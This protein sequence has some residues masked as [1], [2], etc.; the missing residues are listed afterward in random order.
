MIEFNKNLD[1]SR[2]FKLGEFLVS[3]KYLT[4]FD[5]CV[6]NDSEIQKFYLLT[7]LVLQPCRDRF[8]AMKI[9]SAYRSPRLNELVGGVPDSQHCLAEAVDFVSMDASAHS[10]YL[11]IINELKWPG[12]VI[13]Y[14]S[15][16]RLHVSLPRIG[17]HMNQFVKKGTQVLQT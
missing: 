10:V 4:A 17:L 13:F 15:E 5:G 2:N 6:L 16:L 14:E 8:G 1:L 12:E 11:F 3:S 7:L 9:T